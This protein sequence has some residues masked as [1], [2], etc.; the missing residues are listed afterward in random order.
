[1]EEEGPVW[2]VRSRG[3]KDEDEA[4]YVDNLPGAR[5]SVM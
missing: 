5:C 4:N 3:R 1:M 2:L